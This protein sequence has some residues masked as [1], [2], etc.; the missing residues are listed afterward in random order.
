MANQLITEIRILISID[1]RQWDKLTNIQKELLVA[2]AGEAQI[3][4][5]SSVKDKMDV[6][7]YDVDVTLAQ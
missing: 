4:A 6:F 3:T 1:Q 5:L 7:T 2:Q